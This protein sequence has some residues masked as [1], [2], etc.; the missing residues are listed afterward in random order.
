MSQIS[1]FFKKYQLLRSLFIY[2]KLYAVSPCRRWLGY[3]HAK[4][5]YE[6]IQERTECFCFPFPYVFFD[7]NVIVIKA[8]AD[9]REEACLRCLQYGNRLSIIQT[10]LK[11][12]ANQLYFLSVSLDSLCNYF[13]FLSCQMRLIIRVYNFFFFSY[14]WVNINYLLYMSIILIIFNQFRSNF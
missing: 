9:W 12:V 7:I 1:T 8:T 3:D 6:R 4:R 14:V 10:F 2:C 5:K 13:H 11:H